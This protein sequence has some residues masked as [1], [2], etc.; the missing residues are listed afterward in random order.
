[1]APDTGV[2]EISP[3][4]RVVLSQDGDDHG[5]IFRALALVDGGGISGNRS[6]ELASKLA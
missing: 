1:M 2:E 5:G 3:Q 4:H 6:V